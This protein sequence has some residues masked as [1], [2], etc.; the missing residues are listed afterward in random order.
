MFQALLASNFKL[1]H[2][3]KILL[4]PDYL[5]TNIINLVIR[6]NDIAHITSL[7]VFSLTSEQKLFRIYFYTYLWYVTLLV[8]NIYLLLH[9][10]FSD[11]YHSSNMIWINFKVIAAIQGPIYNNPHFQPPCGKAAMLNL[12]KTFLWFT[13]STQA[14][15]GFFFPYHWSN[16]GIACLKSNQQ[17]FIFQLYNI[18]LPHNVL[19]IY[20][21]NVWAQ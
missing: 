17:G 15:L 13:L 12:L 18:M 7:N 10:L 19:W 3:N 16:P 2:S 8:A 1:D 9:K 5:K 21:S 6:N 14:V 4:Y 11:A 20:C